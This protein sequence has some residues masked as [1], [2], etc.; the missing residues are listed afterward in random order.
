MNGLDL[1][2]RMEQ[3]ATRFGARMVYEDA[4]SLAVNPDGSFTVEAG[5]TTYIAQAVIATAGADYNKL[6]IPAKKNSRGA[7]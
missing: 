4:R 3:Q 6:G 1:S 2:V 5:D 7:A